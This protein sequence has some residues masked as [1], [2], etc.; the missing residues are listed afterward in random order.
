M[1]Y[2]P[3]I[4][5]IIPFKITHPSL[6]LKRKISYI[7]IVTAIVT[8]ENKKLSSDYNLGILPYYPVKVARILISKIYVGK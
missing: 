4:Q 5:L 1:T 3:I 2:S 6:A 8:I 7:E